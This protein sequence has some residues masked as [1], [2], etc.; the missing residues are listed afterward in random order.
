MN[1]MGTLGGDDSIAHDINSRS[2]VVGEAETAGNIT[3]A[4]LYRDGAM[5]DLGTLGGAGAFSVAFAVNSRRE[6]V[7]A[8]SASDGRLH[9]FL[10]SRG[11]MVDL[12]ERGLPLS[13]LPRDLNSA[14]EIVGD[15]E[16]DGQQHA[17][18]FRRGHVIELSVFGG[19][20]SAASAVNAAGVVVGAAALTADGFLGPFH[21]FVYRHGSTTEIGTLGGEVSSPLDVNERGDVVGFSTTADGT[22]HAFLYRRGDLIDLNDALGGESNALLSDASGINNRGEITGDMYVNGELHAFVLVPR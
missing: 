13:A 16:R 6:V 2:D 1:D 5:Q 22:N 9:P 7:G 18:V 19:S 4:F 15:F 3:H 14:G 8:S 11:L 20:A 10:Y 12:S 17:F 21:G